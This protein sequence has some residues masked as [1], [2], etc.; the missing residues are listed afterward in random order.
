[1]ER[2]M[3]TSKDE[4]DRVETVVPRTLPQPEKEPAPR[5][6]ANDPAPL[7]VPAPKRKVA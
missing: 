6:P 2:T 3:R 7:A 4:P 1:M 5:Q